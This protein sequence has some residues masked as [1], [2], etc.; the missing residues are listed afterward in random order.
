MGYCYGAP[1]ETTVQTSDQLALYSTTQ[2]QPRRASVSA[3]ADAVESLHPTPDSILDISSLYT[4]RSTTSAVVALTSTP[5]PFG[6][7]V[8][9]AS[10]TIPSLQASLTPDFTNGR[11]IATRDIQALEYVVGFTGDWASGSIL[12][13]QV[14]LGDPTNLFTA[15]FAFALTGTTAATFSGTLGGPTSN[16]NDTQGILR[17]GQIVRV[18]AS[19]STPG[20]LNLGRIEFTVR[21]LDGK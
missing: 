19:I 1:I 2:G 21:P 20:N 9:K 12:T 10:A 13:L 17:A 16:L 4:M 6:T 15:P 5:T 14:Q 18:V 8:Y 11:F 7:T 3:L